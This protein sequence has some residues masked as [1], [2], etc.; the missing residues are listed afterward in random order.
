MPK[1]NSIVI[2]SAGGPVFTDKVDNRG[3][4]ISGRSD[5][6]THGLNADEISRLFDNLFEKIDQHSELSDEDKADAKV[7]IQEI[8]Q[9]IA[10]KEQASESFIMRRLRN[11]GRMAPDILEATLALIVNPA[12]GLGVIAR[13]IAEKAKAASL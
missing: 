9:E 2:N 4:K 6:H 1:K 3:G 8:R 13:K 11:L 5:R 12:L 10:K 7:E